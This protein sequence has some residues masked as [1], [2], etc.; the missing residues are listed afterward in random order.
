[1]PN[2]KHVIAEQ[3][4]HDIHHEQPDLVVAAIRSVV[5]AVR[6]PASWETP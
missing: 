2:S 4:G 3:S 1:V 5:E 6:D